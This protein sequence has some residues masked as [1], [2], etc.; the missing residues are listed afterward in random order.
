MARINQW[1]NTMTTN[2]YVRGVRD[3]DWERFDGRV[4]QRGYYG[5]CPLL[6]AN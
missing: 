1:L 3:H 6:L 5:Y 2:A 4:W